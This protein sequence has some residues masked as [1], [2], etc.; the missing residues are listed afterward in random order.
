MERKELYKLRGCKQDIAQ[1]R[2]EIDRLQARI[3]SPRIAAYG[4]ERAQSSGRGHAIPDGIAQMDALIARY[5][6]EVS[7]ALALQAEFERMIERLRPL[8]KRI[9][10]Y[11]YIDALT[12]EEIAR[13]THY[14]VRHV[15]RIARRGERAEWGEEQT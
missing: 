4:Y 14:S 12:W 13:K 8:E 11:Y 15:M 7:R 5:K 1:L 3:T 10:R 9:L 2:D 6:A